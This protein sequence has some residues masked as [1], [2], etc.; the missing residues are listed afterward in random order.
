MVCHCEEARSL[1]WTS[2]WCALHARGTPSSAWK[3]DE[4]WSVPA[5]VR[6]WWCWRW[7][8]GMHSSSQLPLMKHRAHHGREEVWMRRGSVEVALRCHAG[9]CC[10][11]AV[12]SSLFDFKKNKGG[13]TPF[14][15]DVD[16][17]RTGVAVSQAWCTFSFWR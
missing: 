8:C 17:L 11:V 16:H 15:F 13:K 5:A 6:R 4:N 9:M 3:R 14:T 2:R 10:S 7:E 1:Q 12:A